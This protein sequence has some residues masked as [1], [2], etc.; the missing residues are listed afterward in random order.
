M[1]NSHAK[2][3]LR[4]SMYREMLRRFIN[5]SFCLVTCL[6]IVARLC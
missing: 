2:L 5:L 3:K 4:V 1:K 6:V